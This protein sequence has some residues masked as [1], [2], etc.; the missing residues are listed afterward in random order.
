MYH[1][2]TAGDAIP[3]ETVDTETQSN[4][5]DFNEL[6]DIECALKVKD[7]YWNVRIWKDGCYGAVEDI[8][9][10]LQ[11]GV[12]LYRVRYEDSD[13]EHFSG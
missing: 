3:V 8:E 9:I 6:V 4:V 12:R 5:S 13:L 1:S 7:P 10:E 2:D 11:S